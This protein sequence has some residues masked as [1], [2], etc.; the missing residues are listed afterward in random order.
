MQGHVGHHPDCWICNAIKRTTR[1]V[2]RE[3]D[4]FSD[5]RP[6]SLWSVDLVTFNYPAKDGSVHFA[7][8][9][10][11]KTRFPDGFTLVN[12]SEFGDKLEA[13]ADRCISSMRHLLTRGLRFSIFSSIVYHAFARLIATYGILSFALLLTL[14]VR[15]R[16]VLLSA[17]STPSVQVTNFFVCFSV[18]LRL[19]RLL[20][21]TLINN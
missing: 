18:F 2:T 12:K 3:R 5:E 11:R 6:G 17:Y 9:R 13:C 16:I 15:C 10:D 8:L 1:K 21:L 19:L 4:R 14:L 20:P 7:C